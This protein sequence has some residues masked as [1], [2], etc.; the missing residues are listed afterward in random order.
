MDNSVCVAIDGHFLNR[1]LATF[2]RARNSGR[3]RIDYQAL[4]SILLPSVFKNDA[5]IMPPENVQ[6][7]YYI[8]YPLLPEDHKKMVMG[9]VKRWGRNDSFG[10]I[11]SADGSE[12]YFVHQ[13]DII[14]Q[15]LRNLQMGSAVRFLPQKKPDGKLV[16]KQVMEQTE[17]SKR[18]VAQEKRD[19]FHE[20]LEEEGYDVVAC[21]PDIYNPSK[22]SKAVDMRIVADVSTAVSEKDDEVV[23]MTGDPNYGFLLSD[24]REDNIKVTLA[25][26]HDSLHPDL[27]NAADFCGVNLLFLDDDEVWESIE[28]AGNNGYE[29]PNVESD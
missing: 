29:E 6:L 19:I 14:M 15:G 1:A 21:R 5:G 9:S 3:A 22:K 27:A 16:A 13:T 25:T 26:F 18:M 23:L 20:M 24:L 10:F 17:W 12:D 2:A 4:K 28:H 7:N 8:G 11:S